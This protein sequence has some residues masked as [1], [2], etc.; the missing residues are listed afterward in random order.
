MLL[1][2]HLVIEDVL[3]YLRVFGQVW[4]ES[5]AYRDCVGAEVIRS[6]LPVRFLPPAKIRRIHR[7]KEMRIIELVEI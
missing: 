3:Q 2:Q 7:A 4:M 5:L 1:V 6:K